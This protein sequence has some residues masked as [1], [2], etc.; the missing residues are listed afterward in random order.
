[1]LLE[2]V[3]FNSKPVIAKA[4]L[5]PYLSMNLKVSDLRRLEFLLHFSNDSEISS[6]L[7]DVLQREYKKIESSTNKN[8]QFCVS[9]QLIRRLKYCK[10][11]IPAGF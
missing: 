1:M 11:L 4:A 10:C 3:I 8:V 2:S 7:T 6:Y 5:M 9:M